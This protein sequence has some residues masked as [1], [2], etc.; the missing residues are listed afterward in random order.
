MKNV[1]VILN[2]KHFPKRSTLSDANKKSKV[3]G[4]IFSILYKRYASFL[5][6]NSNLNPPV[7]ILKVVDSTT[8]SLFSDILKGT[9]HNNR[10]KEKSGIK[11]HTIIICNIYNGVLMIFTL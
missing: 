7:K 1:S 3:F 8:I 11:M 5:S 4:A 10:R 2:L 9:G 6:D